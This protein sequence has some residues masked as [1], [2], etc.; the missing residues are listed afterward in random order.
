M[1]DVDKFHVCLRFV[2]SLR[3][4]FILVKKQREYLMLIVVLCILW[5]D[6]Y[7]SDIL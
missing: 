2:N 6:C 3:I 5:F 4:V 1:E 7:C